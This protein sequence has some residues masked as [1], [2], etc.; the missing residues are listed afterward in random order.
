MAQNNLFWQES[1]AA[2]IASATLTG[3]TR[4]CGA[5]SGQ[6]AAY[7]AFNA[8]AFADVAGTLRIECSYDGTTWRRC[9]ADQA[10]GAGAALILSVP[11]FAPNYRAVYVNGGAGQAQFLCGTS[12]TA[13]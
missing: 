4:S 8:Y 11:V 5:A 7:A 12:F 1:G 6:A 10:V 9:T 13:A 2:L 3:L